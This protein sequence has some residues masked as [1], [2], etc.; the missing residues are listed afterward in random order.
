MMEF[1]GFAAFAMHLVELEIE[2]LEGLEHGARIIEEEAKHEIGT[3][4]GAAGPFA[5][6]PELKDGTQRQREAA[7]YPANE[8]LLVTGDMRDSIEHKVGHNE[9][10]V[11]S[12]S[13]VAVYQEVGTSHIKP[14]SFLGGAAVRKEK[15]VRDHMAGPVVGVLA[16]GMA[17]QLF[18][19]I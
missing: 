18:K 10:W 9:A 1:K 16:G 6:W 11:G 4:Q 13:D 8:P 7:G 2:K 5:A 3:Y 14:R 12:D 19:V 15:E 17:A